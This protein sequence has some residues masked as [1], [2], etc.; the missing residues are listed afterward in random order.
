[1]SQCK[2]CG[3]R[4][5]PGSI[6]CWTC[7]TEARRNSDGPGKGKSPDHLRGH[8]PHTE[9]WIRA[10]DRAFVKHMESLGYVKREGQQSQRNAV[11][12]AA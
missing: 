1:M 5:H 7:H 3:K 4:C 9:E 6:R 12:G 2:D 10:Q 8:M 11:G